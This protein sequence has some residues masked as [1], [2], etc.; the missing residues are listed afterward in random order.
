MPR[1]AA[2]SCGPDLITASKEDTKL[3][4]QAA[5][6]QQAAH[7]AGRLVAAVVGLQHGAVVGPTVPAAGPRA[8]TGRLMGA[9]TLELAAL[10]KGNAAVPCGT[11]GLG[12][13][14]AAAGGSSHGHTCPPGTQ[15]ARAMPSTAHPRDSHNVP[16]SIQPLAH[17]N[18]YQ[19][20]T[21]AVKRKKITP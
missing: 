8:V 4:L 14:L 5:H 16:A 13:A 10:E 17:A 12:K 1:G 15:G 3:L 21:G 2:P 19:H 9:S 18:D 6:P 7:P 20:E 11:D